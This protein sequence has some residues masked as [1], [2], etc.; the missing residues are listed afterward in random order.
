LDTSTDITIYHT[1]LSKLLK[2]ICKTGSKNKVVPDFCYLA[3]DKFVRGVLDGYL[4]GDGAIHSIFSYTTIS[5]DLGHGIALLLKRFGIHTKIY[6]GKT[7]FNPY[8]TFTIKNYSKFKHLTLT[9]RK[10]MWKLFKYTSKREVNLRYFGN[11]VMEKVIKKEELPS[12]HK[13]VYDLTVKDNPNFLLFNSISVSDTFHNAGV[14]TNSNINH[15]VPRIK[16]LVRATKNQKCPSTTIYL[17]DEYKTKREDVK[18]IVNDFKRNKIS[19]FIKSSTLYYDPDIFNSVIEEDRQFMKEHYEFNL[20]EDINTI[21]PWVLRI[22]IDELVLLSKK[23][24]MMDLFYYFYSTYYSKYKI[25]IIYSDENSKHLVFHLRLLHNDINDLVDKKEQIN[26]K[27]YL[28]TILKINNSLTHK[29]I[30]SNKD[31]TNMTKLKNI[32]KK[33]YI[34]HEE[35]IYIIK[36]INIEDE[37]GVIMEEKT[38]NNFIVSVKKDIYEREEFVSLYN[39]HNIK[40]KKTINFIKED[41]QYNYFDITFNDNLIM[42]QE[43]ITN[44]DQEILTKI[45]SDIMKN[46]IISGIDNI[47]NITLR[48]IKTPITKKSGDTN[49]QKEI[50]IDT[51]GINLQEIMKLYNYID[52]DKTFSNDLYETYNMMGIEAARNL[53]K[54]EIRNVI[55]FSG[56]YINDKHILLLVDFMTYR[57]VITSIDRHGMNK[58][59][60]DVLTMASFEQPCHHFSEASVYNT[61]DNMNGIA[62]NLIMG[63]VGKFGSGSVNAVFD[64][65]KLKTEHYDNKIQR[66]NKRI[67][68]NLSD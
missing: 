67:V 39:K 43:Y 26:Y 8:W 25:H 13:Y 9:N 1:L 34:S 60:V 11:N 64:I 32:Y 47:N 24:S 35:D 14:S 52:Q 33:Y 46:G 2:Q 45:E 20:E 66:E 48:E 5:E 57:G 31:N 49:Y 53:L 55:T 38:Y 3:N 50:V 17:K 10:K 7:K 61:S 65:E 41:E 27:K 58:S 23:F 19:N 62:P 36:N 59:N 37:I 44:G 22:E 54:R 21:S 28:D 12:S 29:L 16:E 15:G 18:T 40:M 63:Q 56:I 30:L 68:I 51:E 4:S 42:E 6:N